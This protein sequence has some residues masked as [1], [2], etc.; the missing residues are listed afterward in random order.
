[1]AAGGVACADDAWE[2]LAAG[3]SLLQLYTALV[4]EGPSLP[5]RIA[6]GL[7]ARMDREGAAHV[8]EV[9]G[10]GIGA[11]EPDRAL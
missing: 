2:R 6:A 9:V 1:V 11:G 3:A 4:Y 8:S 7:L 5:R 10:S